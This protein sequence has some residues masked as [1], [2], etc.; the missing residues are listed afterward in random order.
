MSPAEKLIYMANQIARNL[1]TAG[2]DHAARQTAEHI[3]AFW[4]PRMKEMILKH[5]DAGGDGLSPI[6]R[7]ALT[8][9]RAHADA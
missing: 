3:I 7:A 2:P 8:E 5:L 9:V 1:E 4:D 6:A